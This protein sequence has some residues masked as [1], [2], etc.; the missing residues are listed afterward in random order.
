MDLFLFYLTAS[1]LTTLAVMIYF[2]EHLRKQIGWYLLGM[3]TFLVVTNFSEYW[4]MMF[5]SIVIFLKTPPFNV[6]ERLLT[7]AAN[8]DTKSKRWI[9]KRHW[10]IKAILYIIAC[11]LASAFIS[12]ISGETTI[13]FFA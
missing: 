7:K 10:S 11:A 4:W 5:V 13:L 3:T 9:S 1:A 12:F 2:R 8:T 6:E